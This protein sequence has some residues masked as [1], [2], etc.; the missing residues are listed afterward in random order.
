MILRY[1]PKLL[2]VGLWSILSLDPSYGLEI[3]FEGEFPE[4]FKAMASSHLKFLWKDW[5]KRW[6]GIEGEREGG[7]RVWVATDESVTQ[8]VDFARARGTRIELNRRIDRGS[9]RSVLDHEL[10]HV[11]FGVFCSGDGC[12]SSLLSEAFAQW[13]SGDF[14][15]I[16]NRSRRFVFAAKAKGWLASQ[17][18]FRASDR[19]FEEAL[20]RL[21]VH[22]LQ[23]GEGEHIE[24]FFKVALQGYLKSEYSRG[25]SRSQ[26]EN[27]LLAV[28]G[29]N[30]KKWI[31]PR[32]QASP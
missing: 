25:D 3:H 13:A 16:A 27:R 10:G 9:I 29:L 15:R 11:F 30:A 1:F 17:N 2:L 4:S 7:I 20:A 14:I 19:V 24:N 31:I 28:L 18:H 32:S 5:R 23:S 6:G 12:G 22:S 8:S 21:L 26:L